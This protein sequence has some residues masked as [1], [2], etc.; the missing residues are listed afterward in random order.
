MLGSGAALACVA[1][2]LWRG[3]SGPWVLVGVVAL[4]VFGPNK[5]APT[6][7]VSNVPVRRARD[8]W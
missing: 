3:C 5:N 4:F 2:A 7:A 8:A 1:R 6:G